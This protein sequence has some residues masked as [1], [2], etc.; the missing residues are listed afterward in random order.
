METRFL[1][2]WILDLAL[3]SFFTQIDPV[4]WN[5]SDSPV[6]RQTFT[7]AVPT[8][9]SEIISEVSI[10]HTD[11]TPIKTNYT[12]NI[13]FSV[14]TSANNY[15]DRVMTLMSTWFQ[16]VDRSKVLFSLCTQCVYLIFTCSYT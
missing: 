2:L 5:S 16:T 15:K 8:N 1:Q 10:P 4:L 13:Y 7:N 6:L 11:G 9:K 12:N 3:T 14:K